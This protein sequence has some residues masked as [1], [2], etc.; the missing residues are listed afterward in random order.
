MNEPV[1]K[2]KWDRVYSPGSSRTCRSSFLVLGCYGSLERKEKRLEDTRIIYWGEIVT[3]GLVAFH[4]REWNVSLSLWKT[5]WKIPYLGNQPT[6]SLIAPNK[7]SLRCSAGSLSLSC[8]PAAS[9]TLHQWDFRDAAADSQR[10][11]FKLQHPHLL[12]PHVTIPVSNS[13]F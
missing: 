3:H 13:W 10:S 7:S 9:L 1:P 6:R 4:L 2:Q 8:A 12:M 5:P 11:P